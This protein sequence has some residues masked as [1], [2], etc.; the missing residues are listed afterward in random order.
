MHSASFALTVA[1]VFCPRAKQGEW[2][3]WL[4]QQ[5]DSLSS[6]SGQVD[7]GLRV[8]GTGPIETTD[9]A[10]FGERMVSFSV[11]QGTVDLTAARRVALGD[12]HRNLSA[13]CDL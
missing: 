6:W 3:S 10:V 7:G 12:F 9:T 2:S 4:R 1:M 13:L 11:R 5:R 8:A